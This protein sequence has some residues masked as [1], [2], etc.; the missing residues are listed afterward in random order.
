MEALEEAEIFTTLS[1]RWVQS[2]WGCKF[3]HNDE[4]TGEHLFHLRSSSHAGGSVPQLLLCLPAG[5]MRL[6]RSCKFSH[7]VGS[8]IESRQMVFMCGKPP[9]YA[10]LSRLVSATEEKPVVIFTGWRCTH[11]VGPGSVASAMLSSVAHVFVVG[12]AASAMILLLGNSPNLTDR[13]LVLLPHDI[14]K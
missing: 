7:S 1:A 3:S 4:I 14:K 10:T 9:E 8:V 11:I 6:K 12:Y 5:W 13:T 2:W